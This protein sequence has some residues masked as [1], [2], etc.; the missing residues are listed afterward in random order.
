MRKVVLLSLIL[1][2]QTTL[3]GVD[4]GELSGNTPNDMDLDG[5][6]G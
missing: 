5:F 6:I 4:S 2:C 3:K 1:S